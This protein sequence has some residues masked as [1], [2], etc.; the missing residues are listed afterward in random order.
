LEELAFSPDDEWLAASY[1]NGHIKIWKVDR[2]IHQ[3]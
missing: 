2:L 3:D 1:S